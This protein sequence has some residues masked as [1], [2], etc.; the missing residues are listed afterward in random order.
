M[1]SET[2]GDGT[3]YGDPN[4]YTQ[5]YHSTY[6]KKTH[7]DWRRRCREYVE[8]EIMPNVHEWEVNKKIPQDAYVKCYDAGLLPCVVGATSGAYDLVPA[9]APEEFDYFHICGDDC[10]DDVHDG[11]TPVR[12]AKSAAESTRS[13]VSSSASG[14]QMCRWGCT[15]SAARTSCCWDIRSAPFPCS[16]PRSRWVSGSRACC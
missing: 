6:Y 11:A 14:L 8:R 3:P 15:S 2:F 5:A 9:Q 4:W 16:K 7:E 10:F 12:T 1:A 13:S